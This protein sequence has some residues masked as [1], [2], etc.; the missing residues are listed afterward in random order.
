M[1]TKKCNKCSVEKPLTE[2]HKGKAYKDGYQPKCKLC[3]KQYYLENNIKLKQ[4]HQNYRNNNKSSINDY[5]KEWRENNK[6]LIKKWHKENKHL[7]S[8]SSKQYYYK[9]VEVIRWRS[10][11]STSLRR[12]NQNKTT[13]TYKMLGYTSSQLKEHLDNQGMDWDLH[14]IDHKIPTTWFKPETP[15]YIVNDLRNLQPLTKEENKVKGNKFCS[16]TSPSYINEIK[17]YIKDKYISKLIY[18]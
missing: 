2:Y 17:L 14:E 15:S 8:I 18:L 9:N 1:S 6:P 13:T 7:N 5:Q 3:V 12:I 16:P 4:Y 10:L 11:L